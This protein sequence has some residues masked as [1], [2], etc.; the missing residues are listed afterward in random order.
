M[1]RMKKEPGKDSKITAKKK[2]HIKSEDANVEKFED[3]KKLVEL[4]QIH[5]VELEHQNEELRI[6]QEELEVSRNKYVNLYDFSPIPYF[7]LDI[8]GV[9]KETNLSASNM[10]GIERKRLINKLFSTYIQQEDRDIFNSFIKNIYNSPVKHTCELQIRNKNKQIFQVLLEGIDLE[11]PLE[12]DKKCQVALIDLT[13]FKE[14]E[15][16]L[17]KSSEELKILNTTKDKF[18][19][20]I[21]HDL[22]SPFNILLNSSDILTE[23]IDNLSNEQ[24][25]KYSSE[26][27]KNLT[28]LYE[29]VNNLLHWSLMQ[30]KILEFTP[31]NIDLYALVNLIIMIL[32]SN[33]ARK[34]ISIMNYV[35][36][37]T[38][39]YADNN[40]LRSIVQNLIVNAIKFTPED[41]QIVISSSINNGLIE[42]SIKDT[43]VGIK[44]ER[45]PGL[46]NFTKFF[47]TNGT[48]GEKGTGLGLPLCQEFVERNEGK[49]WVESEL[50][51]GSKFIFTLPKAIL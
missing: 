15:E 18:F 16:S 2:I 49:I 13:K 35:E 17:N 32:N 21:A 25:R 39:V 47:T 44:S 20:I 30:R 46:F 31:E 7:T 37:E 38:F 28:T 41:G 36:T 50:G 14:I 5:Q 40:M 6:T 24:I 42:V 26:I 10:L 29:L 12:P 11:D 1:E 9:I 45:I 48:E 3:V 22:R 19:S 4:L 23:E 8:G 34:N 33:A 27:N 51:K 43:G